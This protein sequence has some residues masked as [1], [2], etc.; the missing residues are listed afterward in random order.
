MSCGICLEKV[1][2]KA[3]RRKQV[4]GILPNCRHCFCFACLKKWRSIK[5]VATSASQSCPECR[6]P[7]NYVY[8]SKIWYEDE[9]RKAAFIAKRNKNM[10]KTD[11]K[12]FRNGLGNCP[13][14]NR[15]MYRHA[16]VD[17]YSVD[18]GSPFESTAEFD[19]DVDAQFERI[20]A[21][22]MNILA[23]SNR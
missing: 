10:R 11:C 4:F 21:T 20:Y 8:R 6:T 18:L 12:S 7:A 9:I 17:G 13:R 15:C 19:S 22:Y 5:E 1:K 3:S 16:T 23:R 2:R 14:A